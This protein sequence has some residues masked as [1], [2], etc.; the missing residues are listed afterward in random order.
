M[1]DQQ[2]LGCPHCYGTKVI[3]NGRKKNGMQT[4]RCKSCGKQFQGSYLYLGAEKRVKQLAL[5]MLTRGSGIR[6]ITYVLNI[7]QTCVLGILKSQ[8][9]IELKPRHQHYHQ[10]QVDELSIVLLEARRRKYGF[11][12]PIVVKPKKY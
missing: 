8:S 6:D 1:K 10:V 5:R 3:K 12:M 4:Y 2:S 7:S 9:G 11:Y